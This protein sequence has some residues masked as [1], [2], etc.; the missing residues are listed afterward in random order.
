MHNYISHL[1]TPNI[2]PHSVYFFNIPIT[3]YNFN[4][5]F[6]YKIRTCGWSGAKTQALIGYTWGAV[7]F[8]DI[9]CFDTKHVSIGN[10]LA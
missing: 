2:F 9:S 8:K 10:L 3:F 7:F 5:V 6:Q 1:P 4:N